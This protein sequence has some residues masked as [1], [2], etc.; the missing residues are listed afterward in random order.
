MSP[1]QAEER[2]RVNPE[3]V[4]LAR[5]SRGLTQGE[6]AKRIGISQGRLSKIEAGL[7][8]APDDVLSRIA[9]VFHYPLGFFSLRDTLLGPGTGEFFHR[10][11]QATPARTL[12]QLHATLNVRMINIGK[13]LQAVEIER[14]DIPRLDPDDLSPSEIARAVRAQW[15]LPMGP[16]TD[17][18]RVVENAGV[19]V[20]SSDFGTPRVDAV[21]RYI[22][23]RPH[24]FFMDSTVPGDRQRLTLAHELGHV[25]MHQS[26]HRDMETQA[27]EF[28]AELLMPAKE[29]R[30]QFDRVDI[31]KLAAM[32]PYWKVSM[33]ALL[34]RASDVG[35]VSPRME[36]YLWS[37]M[38]KAGYRTREPAEIDVP[39]EEPRLLQ[40][41]IDVHRSELGYGLEDLSE[42][43][44]LVEDEA[45]ATYA[46]TPTKSERKARLRALPGERTA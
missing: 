6:A 15:Q 45:Q 44:G 23:G 21:S 5:E 46:I 18:V 40:E 26:L 39:H 1:R 34:K 13:L 31:P 33:A 25:V 42:L 14:D 7:A 11:R 27:Y 37:Q 17:L 2:R 24:V 41:I 9:D 16:I 20:V 10:K 8:P 19:I 3:M 4:T 32:K 36:R 43:M 12:R 28:A 35:K 30:S 22:P 38:G 29:I